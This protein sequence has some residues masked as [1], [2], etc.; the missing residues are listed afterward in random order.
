MR[1]KPRLHLLGDFHFLRGA[2][3][4]FQLLSDR[5]TLRFDPSVFFV[6]GYQRKGVPIWIFEAGEHSAPIGCLRRMA[7]TYAAL[8]PFI[9]LGC[10]IFGYE[11]NPSGLPDKLVF[12]RVRLRSDE[13]QHDGAV[14]GSNCQPADA[15]FGLVINNE[16][17]SELIQIEAQTAFLI[18]DKNC[19]NAT[20]KYGP[21][22][23]EGKMERTLTSVNDELAMGVIISRGG[24]APLARSQTSTMI[25]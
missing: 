25:L 7:K 9:K 18:A 22:R 15:I 24:L 1:K 17:E 8:A 19:D 23:S 6:K 13:R 2:P 20:R 14:R 5:A 4:S 3:F 21:C 12:F 10:D 11:S 16:A